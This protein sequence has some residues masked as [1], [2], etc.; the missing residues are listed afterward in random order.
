VIRSVATNNYN[1]IDPALF[2]DATASYGW[3]LVR[4]GPV[5]RWWNSTKD[6]QAHRPDSPMVFAGVEQLHRSGRARPSRE[7]LLSVRKLGQCC[8]GTNST[9]EIRMGRSDTVTGPY[10]DRDGKD[11]MQ[12]AAACSCNRPA[13]SLARATPQFW[14]EGDNSYVSIHYYDGDRRVRSHSPIREH[15]VGRG[16]LAPRRQ[17]CSSLTHCDASAVRHVLQMISALFG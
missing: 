16:R 6:R 12:A 5:S 15:R 8:R 7:R 1:C 11:L 17:V 13:A 14:T 3:H 2:R 10:R 9:Y 4:I